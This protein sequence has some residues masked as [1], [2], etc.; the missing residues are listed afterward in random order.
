[1][2][3]ETARMSLN[4]IERMFL[5]I[6]SA[7]GDSAEPIEINFYWH[8][9]EPLLIPP[10]VYRRIFEIQRRVFAES[11]HRVTNS[12]QSN[13][14]V[15]NDDHIRL[16]REFDAVGV[17]LDLFTGL[18]VDKHGRDAE[19]RALENLEKVR[20]AGIPVAGITVLSKRNAARIAEIYDFY[21]ERRMPF[22]I[23]PLEKGL[24]RPGQDFELGPR[25]VLAA[26]CTLADIWLADEAPVQI[27]PLDRYLLLVIHA[28]RRPENRLPRYNPS[29]LASVLLVDTD[30]SVYTYG[31]RFGRRL[32]NIFTMPLD[33]IL[34]SA[35]YRESVEGALS[36]I[37]ET[38]HSCRYYERACTGD[39]VGEGLQDFNEYEEDG[40]VRCI[41]ARGIIQHMET[42]LTEAGTICGGTTHNDMKVLAGRST[43]PVQ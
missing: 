42:R 36:R 11:I 34:A 33:H 24:Y 10:D 15:I 19:H 23:L 22:R 41:V 1:M 32:G 30:G 12:T 13:F 37:R 38:C 43:L 17:S 21:R 14:T 18:R 7:Y 40:S 20:A 31:E 5:N 4:D 16:L 25:D 39:P 9:G 28:N 6:N 2:L 3:G 35:E 27:M 29:H 26:Y 8:G